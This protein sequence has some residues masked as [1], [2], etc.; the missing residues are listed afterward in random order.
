[1][2]QLEIRMVERTALLTQGGEDQ[3]CRQAK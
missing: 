1:L 3:L 2:I